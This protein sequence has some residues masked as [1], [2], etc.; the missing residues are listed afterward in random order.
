VTGRRIAV[1][2]LLVAAGATAWETPSAFHSVS[3]SISEWIGTRTEERELAP[4]RTVGVDERALLA[5]QRLIPPDAI[6]HV[7]PGPPNPAVGVAHFAYRPLSF[8]WLFPRRY[9]NLP[10]EAAWVLAYDGALRG[11]PLTYSR[12]WRVAPNA[13]VAE[14]RR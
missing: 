1:L 13:V 10:R 6:Y 11:L 14:V 2:V 12:V 3:D 5:A 4:A 9:T 7:A 8:Y